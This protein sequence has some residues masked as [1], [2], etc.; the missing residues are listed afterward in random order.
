MVLLVKTSP[1]NLAKQPS[2][3]PSQPAALSIRSP[4][5]RQAKNMLVEGCWKRMEKRGT[6]CEA[7]VKEL[8]QSSISLYVQV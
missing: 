1:Q 8:S 3:Q 6:I 7:V 5:W 4:R 2:A